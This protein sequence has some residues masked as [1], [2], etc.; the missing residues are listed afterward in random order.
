MRLLRFPLTVLLALVVLV[1]IGVLYRLGTSGRTN[2]VVLTTV[3]PGIERIDIVP[4]PFTAFDWLI[5]VIAIAFQA[6][7]FYV[8]WR[9]WH[10]ARGRDS[11]R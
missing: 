2:R 6:G 11:G 4:I 1:D 3:H 10:R 8:V 9:I 7:L 5:L